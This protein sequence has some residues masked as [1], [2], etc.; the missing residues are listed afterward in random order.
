MREGEVTFAGHAQDC[1]DEVLLRH[2]G[3]CAAAARASPGSSA[4][5]PPTR[6]APA[7]S[8]AHVSGSSAGGLDEAAIADSAVSVRRQARRSA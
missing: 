8:F 6:C 2:L 7:T 4:P 1:T 5:T 3:V